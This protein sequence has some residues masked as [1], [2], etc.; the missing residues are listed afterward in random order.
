MVIAYPYY[1]EKSRLKAKLKK[2][3]ITIMEKKNLFAIT[4]AA[5]CLLLV[6]FNSANATLLTDYF[7]ITLSVDGSGTFNNSWTPTP[8][9]T[10]YVVGDWDSTSGAPNPSPFGSNGEAFDVEALYID[11]IGTDFLF[12]IVTSVPEAGYDGA[13][14]GWSGY[15]FNPSD[16]RIDAGGGK[17][18]YGIKSTG[19]NQGEIWKDATWSYDKGSAGYPSGYPDSGSTMYNNM[20]VGTGTKTGDVTS[21][22]YYDAQITEGNYGTYVIEGIISKSVLGNPGKGAS[23]GLEFSPDCN[24]DH[25]SITGD[26]DGSSVPVPEPSS[27]LLIST[28][29]AV[30]AFLKKK[31]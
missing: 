24:N 31:R 18:E 26:I 28:G 17:Y 19:I 7:G 12:A 4:I 15:N 27:V 9:T 1:Q 30:F 6:S 10:D 2:G 25:L 29:I 3:N 13:P 21:F 16:I 20:H 5:V 22:S 14:F 8:L 11:D 23:I